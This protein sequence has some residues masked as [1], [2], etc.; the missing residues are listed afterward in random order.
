MLAPLTRTSPSRPG[1][2]ALAAILALGSVLGAS[3][4][5]AAWIGVNGSSGG[6]Y[7]THDWVIDQALKVL[8]GRAN[9]WFNAAA[10]R[11]A[12]DDPD[13]A[14]EHSYDHVYRDTGIR[15]GA[16]HRVAEHYAAAVR[17][18][19]QGRY[20]DASTQIGLLSHYY[21]DILQPYHSHYDGIGQTAPHRN[22]ELM[23]EAQIGDAN[24]RPDWSSTRRTVSQISNV[25]SEAIAAAAFSRGKFPSL[26]AQ[27][28]AHPTTITSTISTI[29]GDVLERGA[30]D[31]AD[32]IWSVSRGV[33]RAPLVDLVV[34]SVKWRYPS[35]TEDFQG[36][37]VTARDS[38]G[39]AIEGLEVRV[40]LPW[41]ETVP[42]YT[43]GTGQ[44]KWSGP[45]RSTPYGVKQTVT[46]RATTDGHTETATTW[47]ATAPTPADGLAGFSSRVDNRSPSAGEYVTVSS[48]L[49]DAAGHPI[50]GIP[51]D[52][53]WD[54]G[55][56]TIK[57]TAVTNSQ[58]V[59]SSRRLIGSTTTYERVTIQAHVESGSRN[60]FSSA[61]FERDPN[62]SITPYKG[63][64][65]DIW[66][67]KFRDD[68]VWLAEE[69]ITTGC[70][71]ELFC[72][73]GLVT[74]GQMA[75]FLSRALD[76]P[77]TG[78]D[79]FTDDEGSS[80]ETSINRLAAAGI[81]SGC[82][83]DRF[84]PNGLVTRAQM[85]SFLV[86]A[87]DL[88]ATSTD[89]FNDDEGLSHEAAINSLAQSGITSGC[90]TNRFC[91]SG[92]VTR[93]QMAAFLRRGLTN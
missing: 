23:V 24:D 72:P 28:V 80:H 67:S 5:A 11:A 32:I 65:V 27:V 19:Q 37:Y 45:P 76:L 4:P 33:G 57:T 91:P 3:L 93:G 21:T 1:R 60:R 64:F 41:G 48:T 47:W 26:H 63:W 30:N 2:L 79:Y 62:D 87:L 12:S 86:R 17:Y 82:A 78:Q 8:D 51:V 10:A 29:T 36:V 31:L 66:G 59:A 83:A 38:S 55:H 61:W 70:D 56:T 85:A 9:G 16:V 52:W 92:I 73:D 40:T 89:H 69:G 42:L 22:Y 49:R 77:A 7:D 75:T 88:P 58:G 50:V 35:K 13:N 44:A 14:D 20:D 53:T 25:R 34:T 68:I 90:G 74:R 43:D 6:N 46:V 15:G 71:V 81:T 39:R 54:Y 18:Y 84:C